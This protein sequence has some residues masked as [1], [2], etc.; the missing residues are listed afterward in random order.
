MKIEEIQ[1]Q[2]MKMWM[3]FLKYWEKRPFSHEYSAKNDNDYEIFRAFKTAYE[4][5]KN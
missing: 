4:L 1:K 2:E 3:A 5:E